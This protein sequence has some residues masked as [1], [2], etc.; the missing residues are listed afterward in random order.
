MNNRKKVLFILT[1]LLSVGVLILTLQLFF[2][3]R[4]FNNVMDNI[5]P[6][7][8]CVFSYS[9]D[10]LPLLIHKYNSMLAI[11][12]HAIEKHPTKTEVMDFFKSVGMC[13]VTEL[14]NSDS[15]RYK[16]TNYKDCEMKVINSF[17]TAILLKKDR[18]DDVMLIFKNDTLINIFDG[19]IPSIVSK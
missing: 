8:H 7:E 9:E 1:G 11:Q 2:Q 15:L 13:H 12:K 14:S 4:M 16:L 6:D 17:H 3:Y 5:F 10:E 18:F 19:H